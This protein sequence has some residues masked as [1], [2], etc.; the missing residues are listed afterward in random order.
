MAITPERLKQVE[1]LYHSTR[2]RE[3]NA[4]GSFLTEACRGDEELRREVESLLGQ[5]DSADVLER[6]A[7]ENA[8]VLLAENARM[9]LE[10]GT[11][12]GPYRIESPLGMGAMGQVYKARDSRLG[13]AVAI[14]IA[15][16]EFIQRFEREAHA[17][18]ALNH[19]NICTLHDIGPDYLVME[20][21]EGPT[22]SERIKKGPLSFDDA[23]AIA[24]QIAD[25][26][27]AA[28]DQGIV[29]RDL[30]PDNIKIKP[31]GTV[32]ILDFGLATAT[33]TP[34]ATSTPQASSFLAMTSGPLTEAE[35]ILGTPPY[36]APEQAQRKP[37]D[38][39]AD[40]WSFGVVL[41][42]MLTGQRVFQGE[43]VADTLA[44]VLTKELDWD[45]IPA[46][47]LPLLRRCLVRDPKRRLR[48]IGDAM[49]LLEIAPD[50]TP[51]RQTWLAKPSL[52]W[53][54]AGSLLLG[55]V[56][57]SFVHFRAAPRETIESQRFQVPLPDK[58]VLQGNRAFSLSP[59]GRAL[60]FPGTSADGTTRIWVRTLDT[61]DAK[62]LPN[63]EIAPAGTMLFWSP[64]G[65]YLA[66]QT[67]GKLK[68]IGLAGAPPE[69]ICDVSGAFIGG[70][71]NRQDLIVF[72]TE[73]M[74]LMK[75]PA[76]GGAAA[77][78]TLLDGAR[79]ERIHGYPTFLPDGEHFFYSRF[80]SRLENTG[81]YV[82]SLDAKPE[83]Q[84]N[85]RVMSSAIGAAFVPVDAGHGKLLF[86]RGGALLSQTFD[87]VRLQLIGEAAPVAD[88][89]GSHRAYGFFAASQ[90]RLIYLNSPGQ[91]AQMTW[92][93]RQG[94][95]LGLFDKPYVDDSGPFFSP[96][97]DRV[98]LSRFDGTGVH[99]W[100]LELARDAATRLTFDEGIHTAPVW[101][102]D[103]SKVAFSS[104]VR[105]SYSLFEKRSNGTGVE[106]LLLKSDERKYPTSWSSD[107]RFLLF[108]SENTKTSLDVWALPMD[109]DPA[110][111]ATRA[112]FPIA[113]TQF[114]ESYAKFAPDGRW[115]AYVSNESGKDEVYVQPFREPSA[116]EA[117]PTTERFLVSR[118]GGT[119]P[120]WRGDG[121]ELYYVSSA[122][123]VMSVQVTTNPKFQTGI[124]QPVLQLPANVHGGD[125]TPDGKRFLVG[126][127]VSESTPAPFTVVLNWQVSHAQNSA[128]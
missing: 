65:R 2:E 31:D 74:G 60:A 70:T 85:R 3:P 18:S 51:T 80:S 95:T 58:V 6:S 98:A 89:V 47:A 16:P 69:S 53:G 75:V 13:R 123:K 103:G 8:T 110:A 12:L 105:G 17:I 46:R 120:S 78:L 125:V 14:K 119:F 54:A 35:M 29:H 107:G 116:G 50:S 118:G 5:N 11:A 9:A 72:G 90:N 101:S 49:A 1:D 82:G 96:Q 34:G 27:E 71:W 56:L 38:K 52:A 92:F 114:A 32:K 88:Q 15:E 122:G 117:V 115:I 10:P 121:K 33:A 26:L 61:L 4:R 84:A 86:Q 112:P 68:K 55:L 28:H 87:T 76:A 94:K 99:I 20:L 57:L 79:Q 63:S 59:D 124:P 23:L 73:T 41:C 62:P 77:A 106:D 25:A 93:D 97:G 100:L 104:A 40:I 81:I 36:M 42:E 66:F 44:A 108:T 113:R 39:R 43:T 64:D 109:G 126:I 67:D 30:K 7:W 111:H 22:L 91:T 19:P 24:R 128:N 127:P 102:P 37:V 45:R 83:D 21:V 48:D